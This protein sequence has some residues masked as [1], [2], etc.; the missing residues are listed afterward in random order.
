MDHNQRLADGRKAGCAPRVMSTKR[1]CYFYKSPGSPCVFAEIFH[2]DVEDIL[3]LLHASSLYV[4]HISSPFYP[5]LRILSPSLLDPFCRPLLACFIVGLY[6]KPPFTS[7]PSF[8]KA[9]P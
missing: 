4:H 5:D 3:Y 6:N 7:L 9:N 8:T 1:T 2:G